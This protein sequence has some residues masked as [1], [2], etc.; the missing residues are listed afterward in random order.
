MNQEP[1]LSIVSPV[2]M[3]EDIV[4]ELVRRIREVAEG[5]NEPYEI[6]LVFDC[7]PDDSWT[8]IEAN[9]QQYPEVKGV[10]LSRNFGQHP[11][12]T[13]GLSVAKGEWVVVMDCDL[14]DQPE[15]I[16]RLLAKAEE[17]FDLVFA[18][19][20]IRQDKRWKRL[21][22][23]YFYQVLGYLTN[24]DQDPS[25]AN[26]GVYNRKV[27][28]A[29]LAMKDYIKYFPTMVKWVGFHRSKIPVEH[30]ARFSGETSYSFSRLVRLALDIM[31]SF[32]DRPL[33]LT[34]RL[35]VLI[36]AGAFLGAIV[37]LIRALIGDITVLG[38]SSLIISLWFLIGIVITILGMLGL[39]IGR[40][41]D[42]VK[43][44]PVFIIDKT[45]NV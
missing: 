42:Q 29:I 34:V 39:Y 41:F 3:A 43:E 23:R 33:R 14:Q 28:K 11:A 15:E 36:S 5:L 13:A 6:I 7:S 26:F 40:I 22:S 8:K 45:H 19:R 4:D 10:K 38:Y 27:V 12:I 35:G 17:G 37:N 25:I 16:P 18:Q 30:A 32:S 44:R 21:V 9:C 31:L 2:Y 20:E 1:Y 24:T